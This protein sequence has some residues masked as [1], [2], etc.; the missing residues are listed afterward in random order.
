MVPF[1]AILRTNLFI[2]VVHVNWLHIMVSIFKNIIFS[3]FIALILYVILIR[4][5]AFA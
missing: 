1:L 5:E 2:C 3:I 4:Q